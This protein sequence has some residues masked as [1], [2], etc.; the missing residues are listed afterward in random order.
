MA[1]AVTAALLALGALPTLEAALADE[2]T[3]PG[4]E[5][6]STAGEGATD[7]NG[8][9]PWRH[10]ADDDTRHGPPP[11]ARGDREQP[12]QAMRRLVHRH[13][14]DMQRWHACV[15]D[16][17]ADCAKPWPPGLAKNRS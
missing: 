17:R 13:A 2:A 16:G 15:T 12:A 14:E 9:P 8:P 11:W 1:A 3:G 4:Q 7:S 10:R 5:E 6:S